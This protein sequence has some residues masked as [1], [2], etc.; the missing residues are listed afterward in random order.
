MRTRTNSAPRFV[1]PA[2]CDN[3][4]Q[5]FEP[6]GNIRPGCLLCL[7]GEYDKGSEILDRPR[8]LPRSALVKT[9]NPAITAHK[10]TS[11]HLLVHYSAW[12]IYTDL[13]LWNCFSTGGLWTVMCPGCR[14]KTEGEL[15]LQYVTKPS[16]TI[17]SYTM[18]V[19]TQLDTMWCFSLRINCGCV[20]PHR[21]KANFSF[22][23]ICSYRAVSQTSLS[24]IQTGW[25]HRRVTFVIGFWSCAQHRYTIHQTM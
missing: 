14:L 20:G 18:A 15:E 21:I 8:P 6:V 2:W 19:S 1:L 5:Q 7:W 10:S 25:M 13:T 22:W 24:L 16:K 17:H 12:F 23:T 11:L 9:C 4:N 3:V